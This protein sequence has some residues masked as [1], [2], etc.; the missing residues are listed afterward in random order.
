MRL[1]IASFD[2]DSMGIRGSHVPHNHRFITA[3][4]DSKLKTRWLV[5]GHR[6]H[7][8]RGWTDDR[9]R[10]RDRN[11]IENFALLN[12]LAVSVLRQD[13]TVKAGVK[14][15]RK[16]PAKAGGRRRRRLKPAGERKRR[17]DYGRLSFWTIRRGQRRGDATDRGA[18]VVPSDRSVGVSLT[19]I[20][21]GT[22]TLQAKG[23]VAPG[24]LPAKPRWV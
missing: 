19:E 10:L 20:V 4:V 14:C 21:G 13:P 7:I 22:P 23:T 11:A 5:F 1:A 9:L 2:A 12:R 6:A 16:P 3:R 17:L 15:K 8:Q 18:V 24:A